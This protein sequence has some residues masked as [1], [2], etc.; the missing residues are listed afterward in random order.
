MTNTGLTHILNTLTDNTLSEL[1]IEL[2][3]AKDEL[4]DALDRLPASSARDE[5][6]KDAD[7]LRRFLALVKA[8]KRTRI[9]RQGDVK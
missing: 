3:F 8:A 7:E 9:R 1:Y 6:A 5:L 4:S 2:G